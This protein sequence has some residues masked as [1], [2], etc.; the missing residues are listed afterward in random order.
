M[1]V[2]EAAG[3][4]KRYR[5]AW[6]VR[7]CTLGIPPGRVAALVGPDGAGKTTLMHMAVG[8]VRPSAGAVTVLGGAPAGSLD[9]LERVA[10]VAQ[11]APLYRNLPVGDMLHL[12][13]N[14]NRRWDQP[15]AEARLAALKI[16]LDGKIGSGRGGQ[17][18]QAALTTAMARPRE[19]LILAEPLAPLDPLAR[20]DFLAS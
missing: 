7:D 9:A 20:H 10:F 4:G 12:A 11:D 1:N 2:I 3:L 19:L 14:L 6:A 15:A 18:A 17:R 16:P 13:R 5:R 8:L